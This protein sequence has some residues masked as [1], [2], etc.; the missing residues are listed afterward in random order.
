MNFTNEML[1]EIYEQ[2]SKLKLSLIS[3]V[4]FTLI[5]SRFSYL[6][7]SLEPS[8]LKDSL[9]KLSLCAH[10]KLSRRRSKQWL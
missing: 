7:S 3:T 2:K 4:K 5:Y 6:L 9:L 8:M 10:G 1:G